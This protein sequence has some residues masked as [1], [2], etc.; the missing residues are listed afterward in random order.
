MV[1]ALVPVEAEP[2]HALQNA[3]DHLCGRALEVGVLN[4]QD[5]RAAV[6]AGEQ[7]VEQRGA[8]A[9]DVQIAGG[10]GRETDAWPERTGGELKEGDIT[11]GRVLMVR[12]EEM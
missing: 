4:A 11:K 3:V 10:R 12:A 6:M 9:A 1:G 5:E 2:A 8:G 7:P